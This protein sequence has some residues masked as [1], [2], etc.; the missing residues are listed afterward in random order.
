MSD[1]KERF[2]TLGFLPSG[3]GGMRGR[4]EDIDIVAV[5]HPFNLKTA[6]DLVPERR[7]GYHCST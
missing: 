4:F 6:V 2:T 1:W 5:E 3:M 7:N